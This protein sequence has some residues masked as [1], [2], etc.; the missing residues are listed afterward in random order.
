MRWKKLRTRSLEINISTHCNLK[1]YGC[2]R[3]SP[4]FA[5]EFF[6]IPQLKRD[7]AALSKVLRVRE[8]K[9]AGGE[10]LLNP[11]LHELINVARASGITKHITLITNGVLLHQ[12]KEELWEKIDGVWV[13]V[14]PGVKRQAS[15]QEIFALGEKH[16]VKVWYKGTDAFNRRMLNKE[17]PDEDLVRKIYSTCYQRSTCHSI[18]KGKY[19]K[20]ATGP[21]V[22]QWLKE[23]GAPG[24]DFSDDGVQLHDNSDLRQE[25]EAYLKNDSPLTACKFCLGGAGKSFAHHQLNEAGVRTS[26]S[27]DHSDIASLIDFER[28]ADAVDRKPEKNSGIL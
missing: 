12:A 14:Y 19:Y 3:G 15:E 17:N 13:S 21:F 2:G 24:D 23:A 26:L 20:C 9:F 18:H 7:L 27:E 4:A 16:N 28:L 1:C 25:L 6:G 10:P 11:D 22:P 8:L 5:E